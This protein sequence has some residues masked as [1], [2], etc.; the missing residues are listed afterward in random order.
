MT[1]TFQEIPKHLKQCSKPKL[2]YRAPWFACIIGIYVMQYIWNH[3][4]NYMHYM[5]FLDIYISMMW[6]NIRLPCVADID[7][8]LQRGPITSILWSI[9]PVRLDIDD[10]PSFMLLR[11]LPSWLSTANS[12]ILT[13]HFFPSLSFHQYWYQQN[14]LLL[15]NHF[16]NS[17]Q[18]CCLH[19][20]TMMLWYRRW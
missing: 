19:I 9:H 18:Y 13:F 11:T 16:L 14:V 3:I 20:L 15:R 10:W 17:Q 4:F 7:L 12:N 6:W 5:H 2:I 1:R 8:A